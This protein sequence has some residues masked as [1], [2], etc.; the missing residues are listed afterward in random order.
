ML[1]RREYF[2]AEI[3]HKLQQTA[4]ASPEE[5]RALLDEFEGQG[6]LSEG[7][8]AEALI[9]AKKTRFGASRIAALLKENGAG[10]DTL[11]RCSA[12]LQGNELER[13]RVVWRKRFRTLPASV[14][15]RA[16]QS[17]FLAGRGFSGAVIA[18]VLRQDNERN[19]ELGET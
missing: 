12:E 17:R 5:L 10:E 4:G 13:A 19:D 15:E 11:A 16:K 3:E 9:T 8:A 1:A 14:E 7:R 18:R 6:W 2:R